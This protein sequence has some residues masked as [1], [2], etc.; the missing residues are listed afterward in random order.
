MNA[1]LLLFFILFASNLSAQDVTVLSTLSDSIRESSGLLY[2][3]QRIITHNDSGGEAALYELDSVTGDVLREVWISNASNVDWEELSSDENYLYIFDFGNNNGNRTDLRIYRV[4]IADYFLSDTL[5]AE[6]TEFFYSD[7]S[8]FNSAP[9]TTNFDA[10]AACVL[11]DS[12]YIF[13]KNWGDKHTN[14]YSLPKI[15]GNHAANKI[16]NLNAQ[17]LVTGAA[18][19]EQ[20][21][22][23]ML[24]G[25]QFPGVFVLELPLYALSAADFSDFNRYEISVPSG[26]SIQIEG[27]TSRNSTSYF[28]SS[29]ESFFGSS[30]LLSFATSALN[31]PEEENE[32]RFLN[33]YPNP[34]NDKLNVEIPES[35][36]VQ[37]CSADGRLH[38]T[39][40]NAEFSCAINTS[41]WNSGIYYVSANFNDGGTLCIPLV[42]R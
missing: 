19:N 25:Y 34:A 17:C 13:T 14:I 42:V 33:V 2:L 31:L 23:L 12:I 38:Y 37:I 5:I 10:E 18:L 22:T 7:Q 6:V 3:N 39:S 29:E 36:I 15:P 16:G 32:S 27:I 1:K 21:Q 20:N 4:S 35:A 41:N 40:G 28:L 11:G 30:S 26:T 9:Y 24:C 8:D